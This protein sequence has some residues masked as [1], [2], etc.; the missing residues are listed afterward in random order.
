VTSFEEQM[1]AAEARRQEEAAESQRR[2]EEQARQAAEAAER[3]RQIRSRAEHLV[4][5][6]RKAAAALRDSGR[7]QSK[8]ANGW[9]FSC[10]ADNTWVGFMISLDGAITAQVQGRELR[11]SEFI[12]EGFFAWNERYMV[13]ASMH[14][15]RDCSVEADEALEK[16]LAEVADFLT[17]PA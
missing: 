16:L 8:Q 9:A 6:V 14:D 2:E 4:P 3:L 1:R 12:R 13:D 17:R 5:E 11:L 7:R 15:W 10:Y